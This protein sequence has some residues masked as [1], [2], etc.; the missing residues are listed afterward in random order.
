MVLKR[1]GVFS[2]ARIAG[3]L[4]CALGLLI[5]LLFALLSTVAGGLAAAAANSGGH[6]LPG[7]FGMI[8]GVGAIVLFPVFYGVLG[9]IMAAIMAG[10]YNLFAGLV[11]GIE[12]DLQ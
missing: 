4:Y 10:L 11:G 5:G 9:F 6:Q 1:V 2:V 7:W 12:L 3:V 8:F